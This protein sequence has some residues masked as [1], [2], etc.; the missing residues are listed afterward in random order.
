M[1]VNFALLARPWVLLSALGLLVGRSWETL[2]T[3]LGRSCAL[4]DA[5]GRSWALLDALGTLLTRFMDLKGSVLDLSE[6]P[7]RLFQDESDQPKRIN[8]NSPQVG[9]KR[10]ENCPITVREDSENQI[11]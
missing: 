2:G 11:Q 1:A 8:A 9:R 3:L 4:L 7:A 5:L 6:E 10:Y